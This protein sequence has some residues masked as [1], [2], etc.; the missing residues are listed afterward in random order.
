MAA[1]RSDLGNLMVSSA[2]PGGYWHDVHIF[3]VLLFGLIPG[4]DHMILNWCCMGS[5]PLTKFPHEFAMWNLQNSPV[6]ILYFFPHI[7]FFT[8]N[9]VT[10]VLFTARWQAAF[11]GLSLQGLLIQLA[12]AAHFL[13]FLF[14]WNTQPI[15]DALI[16]VLPS[17]ISQL[18]VR[19]WGHVSSVRHSKKTILYILHDSNSVS[20]FLLSHILYCVCFQR[21]G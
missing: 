13:L 10:I 20:A 15:K 3:F 1:C 11:P 5:S 19:L 7:W 21:Q 16:F 8:D 17:V 18:P 12:L 4:P 14:L 2:S 9:C 6:M